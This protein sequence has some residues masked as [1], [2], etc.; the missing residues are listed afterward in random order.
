[1]GKAEPVL[2]RRSDHQLTFEERKAREDTV[3]KISYVVG[4]LVDIRDSIEDLIDELVPPPSEEM[5]ESATSEG[6][7]ERAVAF[8]RG[9]GKDGASDPT[10]T[11]ARSKPKK[12]R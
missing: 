9:K 11:S 12:A 5:I 10:K 4:I 8:P 6:P 7:P 1:M 2:S 3:D